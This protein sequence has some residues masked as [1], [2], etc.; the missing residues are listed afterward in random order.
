MGKIICD[1]HTSQQNYNNCSIEIMQPLYYSRNIHTPSP[2]PFPPS[3]PPC[4]G[5]VTTWLLSSP[6]LN[7]GQG[8][9][10]VFSGKTL[11]SHIASLCAD[12]QMG[13]SE[14]NGGGSPVWTSVPCWGGG[15]GCR[16][17][18]SS[19]MLWKRYLMPKGCYLLA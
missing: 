12:V 6:G 11:S 14:F 1:T 19:F 3:S 5:T 17:T 4:G 18:C 8:H 16:N 2:P 7:P 15:G 10:I 9:C 13:T